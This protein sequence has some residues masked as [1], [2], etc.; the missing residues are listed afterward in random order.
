[1]SAYVFLCDDTTE[2]EC[3]KRGLAGT[4]QHNA[5]WVL[6]LQVADTIYVYNFQ[7]GIVHGPVVADS[8]ADCHE[9]GAWGGRFPIQVRFSMAPNFRTARAANFA[10]VRTLK[11]LRRGGPLDSTGENELRP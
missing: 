7:S 6:N 2:E 3:F 9:S 11:I 4:T 1:M 8:T 5:V 10:S